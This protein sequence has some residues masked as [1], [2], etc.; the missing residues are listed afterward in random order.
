[1]EGVDGMENCISA[2]AQARSGQNGATVAVGAPFLL[3]ANLNL[4][5]M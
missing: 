1:M 2:D 5:Q 3:G 4:E